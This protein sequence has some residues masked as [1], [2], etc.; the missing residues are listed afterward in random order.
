MN[1]ATCGESPHFIVARGLGCNSL[2]VKGYSQVS[3]DLA[4]G[5]A[6]AICAEDKHGKTE[7]LLTLAGRMLPTE[8]RLRVEGEDVSS[9]RALNKV[10]KVSGLGF[11]AH[12]ND[13]EKV[14]RVRTVT[15]A[16]LGLAGKRSNRAA[17]LAYLEQW[18]IA[19][20]ADKAIEELPAATYDLLGIALGMAA[21]PKILVVDDI[22]RDVTDDESRA[23]ADRLITL[24]HTTGTTVVC[25]VI[26]YRLAER[27]DSATCISE[28]A[29]RQR[30]AFYGEAVTKE[31]A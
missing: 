4:A 31:V 7:L 22:E 29:A 30:D 25:G 13:V 5:C 16:E 3:L 24:A 20:V 11:F 14:L 2:R 12:V 19:D 18:G 9:L 26:D 15:S 8:G 28:D 1:G 27:F 17:A 10:R 23:L 6:H 21:D